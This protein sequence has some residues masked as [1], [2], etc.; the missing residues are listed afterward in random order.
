ML[1]NLGNSLHKEDFGSKI[2]CGSR[3]E[4][5]QGEANLTYSMFGT[6]N[7]KQK[8]FYILV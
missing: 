8:V 2:V 7:R 4:A 5:E 3:K 6:T 1:W